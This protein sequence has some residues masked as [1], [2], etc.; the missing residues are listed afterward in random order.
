MATT[1]VHQRSGDV[2][3]PSQID[4]VVPGPVVEKNGESEGPQPVKGKAG[5][6]RKDAYDVDF[7]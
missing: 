5:I 7:S 1:E 2:D 6:R 4:G 3:L